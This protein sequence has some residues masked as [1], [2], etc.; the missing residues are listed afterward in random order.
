MCVGGYT[1][2][3]VGKACWKNCASI[4]NSPGT[5]VNTTECSCNAGFYFVNNS[6]EINCSA[7][8]GATTA[9]SSS[10]CNC[11]S[12]LNWES[13]ICVRNCSALANTN[14]V[15]SDPTAC[16]CKS[17]YA[18]SGSGCA[19]NCSAVANSAGASASGCACNSGYSWSGS[20]CAETGTGPNLGLILGVS[21]GV[22]VPVAILLLAGIAVA[23]Y[24][25]KKRHRQPRLQIIRP[26][27]L[28]NVP[29][30]QVTPAVT[31]TSNIFDARIQQTQ[32]SNL[33]SMK[34]MNTMSTLPPPTFTNIPTQA[35]LI[36]PVAAASTP[37]T[38]P[39]P[40]IT[41]APTLDGAS[42]RITPKP[43]HSSVLRQTMNNISTHSSAIRPT[44]STNLQLTPQSTLRKA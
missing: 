11:Q 12:G 40:I 21:I 4:P 32:V 2:N 3:K 35:S 24:Q 29:N 25:A 8:A 1:W 19:I 13:N 27:Y 7:I 36:R 18:W 17:T 38:N 34:S 33:K 26:P 43:P 15:A 39:I 28:Q 22:G 16:A 31:S 23:I 42:L 6:C 5:N 20:I 30:L 14:G 41:R 10:T 44:T 37:F 9:T